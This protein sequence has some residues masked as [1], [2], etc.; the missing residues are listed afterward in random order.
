MLLSRATGLK[1]GPGARDF[2]S[3]PLTF[4]V[5][6]CAEHGFKPKSKKAFV[7]HFLL[8]FSDP[9]VLLAKNGEGNSVFEFA[10]K[11]HHSKESAKKAGRETLVEMLSDRLRVSGLWECDR[12]LAPMGVSALA[13]STVAA[14]LV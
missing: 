9:K 1:F 4:F 12:A 2:H 11:L 3:H 7:L 13:I 8:E 6:K 14:F 10:L 5:W